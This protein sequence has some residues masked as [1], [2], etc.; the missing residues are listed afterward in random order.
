M[1]KIRIEGKEDE[2]NKYINYLRQDENLEVNSVSEI[3]PAKGMSI[4]K[5]CFV[6]IETNNIKLKEN[7]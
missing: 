3:K 4:Y 7:N 6:E 2:I 5:L 1:I